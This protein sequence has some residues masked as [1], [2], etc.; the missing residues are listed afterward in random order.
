M[1]GSGETS[2]Q[3]SLFSYLGGP[4]LEID[5]NPECNMFHAV[6][7]IVLTQLCVHSRP[8]MYIS[9]WGIH[10]WREKERTNPTHEIKAES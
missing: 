2:K 5:T 8:I 1:K 6:F 10:I 3:A 4:D 9:L 7:V